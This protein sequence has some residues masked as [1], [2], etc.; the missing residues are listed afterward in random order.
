MGTWDN[1]EA[2]RGYPGPVDI[3]GAERDEVI[4]IE[5]ARALAQSV[6]QAKFHA[7]PGGHGWA[8]ERD[9]QFRRE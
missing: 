5:H 8:N 1:V 3:F 6:P 4:P 9:V 2:L 7:I